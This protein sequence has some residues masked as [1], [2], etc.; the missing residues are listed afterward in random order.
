MSWITNWWD[1]LLQ[2][3]MWKSVLS[4]FHALDWCLL[5]LL[6]VGVIYGIRQGFWAVLADLI[7]IV[8]AIVLTFEFGEV[9]SH[10][11]SKFIG[12]FPS[13]WG[14]LVGFVLGGVIFWLV[15]TFANGCSR[16]ARRIQ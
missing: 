1:G 14:P 11:I 2:S 10:Y 12:F 6:V 13:H 4:Q 8:I 5:F 3:F 16:F 7:R 15:A 9:I